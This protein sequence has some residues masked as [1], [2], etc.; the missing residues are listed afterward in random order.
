VTFEDGLESLA[1]DAAETVNTNAHGNSFRTRA[2][3]SLLP[4][5]RTGDDT[6]VGILSGDTSRMPRRAGRAL[7]GPARLRQALSNFT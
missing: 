2:T 4:S 7:R 1:A 3:R 5:Y 6:E